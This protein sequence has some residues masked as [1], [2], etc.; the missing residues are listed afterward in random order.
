MSRPAVSPDQIR[1]TVLA[2]LAEAGDAQPPT[3]DRF[4]QVVSV[5]KLRARLGA[6]DPAML[7]RVLNVIESELVRAGLAGIAIPDLPDTVAE[8]MRA[9]WLS[10][11]SIQLD[12]VVRLKSEAT[13]RVEAADAARHDAELKVDLLRGELAALHEQLGARDTDLATVRAE[14]RATSTRTAELEIVASELHS[15]LAKA[16]A[17][18]AQAGRAHAEALASVHARYEALSEQLLQETSYQRYAFQAERER[19]AGQIVEAAQR[20]TALESLRER[21]LADLAAERDAHRQ[22]AAEAAA[23]KGVVTEQRIALQ[24]TKRPAPR[25]PRASAV[26][27]PARPPGSAPVDATAAARRRAR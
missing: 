10:A 12:D 22:V 2:M 23:L 19:L 17:D 3:A 27:A 16:T 21:L 15:Q 11:V 18:A 24:A 8:Q 5:R 26:A 25:A 9:L 14:L 4:R 1:T 13:R 20:V 6:G 7:S